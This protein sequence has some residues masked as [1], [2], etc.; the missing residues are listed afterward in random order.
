MKEVVMKI[1][2]LPHILPVPYFGRLR[3]NVSGPLAG[4]V[5]FLSSIPCLFDLDVR[6]RVMDRFPDYTQI[7]TL[8]PGQ[9]LTLATTNPALVNEL[10]RLAND[11]MA[12]LVG[13][14]PDRFKGFA[15]SLP[16]HDPERAL[17]ELDRSIN[18]LRASAGQIEASVNDLH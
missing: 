14:Y 10:V 18:S 5:H 15:A 1:D 2:A 8:V 13:K 3:A 6:F 4:S 12:E 9:H 7:L 17:D 11:G 16:M